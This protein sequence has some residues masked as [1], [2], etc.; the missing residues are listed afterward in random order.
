MK[1]QTIKTKIRSAYEDGVREGKL[2]NNYQAEVEKLKARNKFLEDLERNAQ[3]S[4]LNTMSVGLEATARALMS[5][6]KQ[7]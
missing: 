7:L 5:Y 4:I 1:K 2:Y 6:H 3:I